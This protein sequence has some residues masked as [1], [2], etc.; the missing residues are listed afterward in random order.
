MKS[1]IKLLQNNELFIQEN[2]QILTTN[3]CKYQCHPITQKVCK[4]CFK[5]LK[6]GYLWPGTIIWLNL[7][8]YFIGSSVCKKPV[9]GEISV[10]VFT[11]FQISVNRFFFGSVFRSCR[12]MKNCPHAPKT[13]PKGLIL[14]LN[15]LYCQMRSI[16]IEFLH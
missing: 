5:F 8:D 13:A 3:N 7:L 6:K 2:I 9:L 12:Y 11:G 10:S 15:L 14:A 1:F 16:L 4:T